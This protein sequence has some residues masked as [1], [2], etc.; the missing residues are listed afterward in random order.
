MPLESNARVVIHGLGRS[1]QNYLAMCPQATLS[2]TDEPFTDTLTLMAQIYGQIGEITAVLKIRQAARH[3]NQSFGI[4]CGDD[5]VGMLEHR[6]DAGHVIDGAS[7][8][9]CRAT[10]HVDELLARNRSV[11]IV[12]DRHQASTPLNFSSRNSGKRFVSSGHADTALPCPR[13]ATSMSLRVRQATAADTDE[14]VSILRE[15]AL[16]LEAQGVPL[17]RTD[18]LDADRLADEVGEGLCFVGNG[19]TGL[20]ATVKFQLEDPLF[21]PDSPAGEAAYLHR[22]AV[23][24]SAA[25]GAV[26]SAMM[27][28]A[29]E[30]TRSLDR[31]FLRLDCEAARPK[32]RAIYEMFGF[33]HHSDRQVGPYHVARYEYSVST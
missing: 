8:T 24:R 18:E 17:W 11:A 25:G 26:S 33:R 30:R 14:V 5:Q 12:R 4:P 9:E 7:L 3:P 15:A 20:I 10:K 21:W 16:W 6:I 31:H 28:W 32:L 2:Q 22:L 19:P 23:R 1:Q 27:H 13:Y 29:V